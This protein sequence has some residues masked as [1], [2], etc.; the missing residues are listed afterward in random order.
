[1]AWP[2]IVQ[3]V[4]AQWLV[5]DHLTEMAERVAG[6]S[7]LAV[8]QRVSERLGSLGAMEARGYI[9][10]RSAA[11]IH[12]ETD[13]LIEQEGAKVARIR[14]RIVAAASASLVETIV[15]QVQQRRQTAVRRAA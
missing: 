12:A 9:R 11:V 1:M 14:E 3:K 2:Q 10:A 13:R 4:I 5:F 15:V 6:R 8:W 7:R